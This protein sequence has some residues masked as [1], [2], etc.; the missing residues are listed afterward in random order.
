M[1]INAITPNIINRRYNT[2][3]FKA[4][5]NND[6][7]QDSTT[8]SGYYKPNQDV[9]QFNRNL[10]VALEVDKDPVGNVVYNMFNRISKAFNHNHHADQPKV[11]NDKE[12]ENYMSSRPYLF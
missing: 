10:K 3:P 8:A 4:G 11:M 12:L 2:I 1:S 6:S 7:V 9:T 5:S